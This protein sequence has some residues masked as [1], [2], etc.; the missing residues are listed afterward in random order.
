MKKQIIESLK[1]NQP[2]PAL[3]DYFI[4]NGGDDIG[5]TAFKQVM[6]LALGFGGQLLLDLLPNVL[7]DYEIDVW[8]NKK[9]QIISI[10]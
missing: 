2:S 9:G 4:T 1:T 5:Y 7:R 8:Y 10:R 6:G 3:Y